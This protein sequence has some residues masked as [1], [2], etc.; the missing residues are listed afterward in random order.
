MPESEPSPDADR[1]PLPC[2][3][4]E[5]LFQVE[6]SRS[7]LDDVLSIPERGGAHGGR[8]LLLE[9]SIPP[10]QLSERG[11]VSAPSDTS[12]RGA[13]ATPLALRYS[14]CDRLLRVCHARRWTHTNRR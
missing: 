14:E 1:D 4:S 7:V 5:L 11:R 9:R 3:W 10:A 2:C 13:Y 6:R 12:S 8:H